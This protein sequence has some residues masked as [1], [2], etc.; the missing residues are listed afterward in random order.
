MATFDVQALKA[1]ISIED[2][3]GPD[4]DMD[5]DDEYMNF[6]ANL[7]GLLPTTFFIDGA[8]FSFDTNIIDVD[9]QRTTCL[10]L[11]HR[12]RDLR[13]LV[14]LARLF[15]LDRDLNNFAKTVDVMAWLLEQFWD[16]VHPKSE[17]GRFAMRSA[18]LGVLDE[19]TIVFSLQYCRLCETRRQ[20]PVTFR[21]YLYSIRE[22]EPRFGEEV[23]T[24]GTLVQAVR[25]F[26]D[27]IAG[28][29]ASLEMLR[30]SFQRIEA[31]WHKNADIL[32]SPKLSN[33]MGTVSR[34]L[35]FLSLG[36]PQAPIT[37]AVAT[38][39]SSA[40][41]TGSSQG[42][43]HVATASD[44]VHALK[45]ATGY[46]LQKEPSSPVLPLII[47]AQQL[48]GKSFQEVLQT[49]MPDKV[50]YAAYQIGGRQ[51]FELP[52]ERLPTFETGGSNYDLPPNTHETANT[53][54]LTDEPSEQAEALDAQPS[55]V[56]MPAYS[57]QTRAQALSLLDEVSAYLKTN[58]PG[59]PIPW[60]I[61]RARALAERDFLSILRAV[62][63][64]S[65]L[66]DL[67]QN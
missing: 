11:L 47:Q 59:S 33:V 18:I 24:E 12:T 21:S 51:F 13:L 9:Q 30:D 57:A 2:P 44:A 62:L 16:P 5:F 60:L 63:P 20:G 15:I 64:E 4:L 26:E 22:A 58:E 54:W 43:R 28:T 23:P 40:E 14:L 36:T 38:G 25:D 45:E 67:D 6:V 66:K 50:G 17:G 32:G 55:T 35:A 39:D 41:A 49:L 19:P 8:P 10:E 31:V 46:F 52:V 1:A 61:E 42:S 65:A 3:C 34:I 27:Q 53:S 29:R 56:S 37:G 48:L 7:E